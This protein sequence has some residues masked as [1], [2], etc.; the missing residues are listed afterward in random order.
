MKTIALTQNKIALIDD[1]DHEALNRHRW[2]AYRDGN[3]WYARRN[4][5]RIK[6]KRFVILMHREILG[7]QKGDR[8]HTDHTDGNGL[9]NRRSNLRICSCQQNQYNQRRREMGT[10]KH[11]GVCWYGGLK[12]WRAD[13][14]INRKRVSLGYFDSEKDAA[15]AYNSAALKHFGEYAVL[16]E[17]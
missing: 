15:K 5:S 3:V 12:K 7:L 14:R 13:I 2:H 8:R 11:K 6:G 9:N 1:E 10:S 16:N 4:S 17:F